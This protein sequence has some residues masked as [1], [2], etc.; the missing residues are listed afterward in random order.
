MISGDYY[1]DKTVEMGQQYEKTYSHAIK[2]N[3]E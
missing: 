2:K 1:N 3:L